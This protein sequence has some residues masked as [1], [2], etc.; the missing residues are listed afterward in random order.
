M[1]QSEKTFNPAGRWVWPE[2]SMTVPG[3][4]LLGVILA[5]QAVPEKSFTT[6][7]TIMAAVMGVLLLASL[8]CMYKTAAARSGFFGYAVGVYRLLAISFCSCVIY[9]NGVLPAA[10]ITGIMIGVYS[11]DA[12][13]IGQERF[14]EPI[15]K[16]GF[17]A[18]WPTILVAI[19]GTACVIRNINRLEEI[20]AP[21]W[22]SGYMAVWM[23]FRTVYISNA[24]R[25]WCSPSRLFQAQGLLIR[26]TIPVQAVAFMTFS[27]GKP[28]NIV[29]AAILAMIVSTLQTLVCKVLPTP[30]I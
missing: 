19:I 26:G 20:A 13:R 4:F 29:A 14:R 21:V 27:T 23:L 15:R 6:Y 25:G 24:V 16:L 5:W 1:T 8:F 11:A 2:F 7:G 10:A 18:W 3:D 9:K 30:E 12:I 17:A 22:M 28:W